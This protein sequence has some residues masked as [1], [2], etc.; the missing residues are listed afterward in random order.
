MA[1]ARKAI[2]I[3]LFLAGTFLAVPPAAAQQFQ[4]APGAPGTLEFPDS[5]VL[6]IATPPSTGVI[7]QNL[8]NSQPSWPSIIAPPKDAPNVLLVLIDDAGYGSN[9]VFG[10][11]V[12][13]P[14]LEK[15]AQRGL[16]YTQMH[17]TAL[18]S[19]TRAALLT[20]RNHHHAGYGDVAEG[21]VGYPGYD[22]ITGPERA[23]VAMTL[24]K[25]GYATAW[26]GKNHNVPIWTATLAHRSRL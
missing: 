20:G 14:T 12:P 17:N 4:G 19:P 2:S 18:C 24:K 8:I 13:T 7:N 11:V 25:N 10:G 3:G 22:T 21:A 23:H 9:S 15:L 16:R 26:F 6:P 1:I 5:R